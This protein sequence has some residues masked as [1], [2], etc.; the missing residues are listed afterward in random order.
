MEVGHAIRLRVSVLAGTTYSVILL[1]IISLKTK[2]DLKSAFVF[3]H[4]R[5]KITYSLH[6]FA[7]SAGALAASAAGAVD[8]AAGAVDSAAGA[9]DSA[10]GAVDSAA[11]GV[12]TG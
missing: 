2:A 7:A 10:A 8:S 5:K 3:C 4:A 1:F 9:G 12:S 6:Y 11:G